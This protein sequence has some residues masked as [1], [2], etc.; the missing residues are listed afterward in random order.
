MWGKRQTIVRDGPS[1]KVC[2]FFLL[3]RWVP[4]FESMLRVRSDLQN[5]EGFA[6][7]GSGC[8]YLL[9]DAEVCTLTCY[10]LGWVRGGFFSFCYYDFEL[11]RVNVLLLQ[12]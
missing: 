7:L 3:L 6:V 5:L 4:Y 8:W 10:R 9:S 11:L 1:A 12:H 2:L